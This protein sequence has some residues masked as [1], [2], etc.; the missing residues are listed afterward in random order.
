VLGYRISYTIAFVSGLAISFF[1][2][3]SFVFKAHQGWKTIILFLLV[4][5]VQY[6]FGLFVLWII[7]G[8]LGLNVTFAPLV[9][10]GLSIPLTYWLS[11]IAF[12]G[13]AGNSNNNISLNKF[14]K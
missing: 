9:V 11:K 13:L 12:T 6:I 1:M 8:Q 2:N 5:L 14:T 10:V 3:K 7:V 4:Y